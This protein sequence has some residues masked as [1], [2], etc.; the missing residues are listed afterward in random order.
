[1]YGQDRGKHAVLIYGQTALDMMLD[2]WREMFWPTSKALRAE[3]EAK[4]AVLKAKEDREKTTSWRIKTWPSRI[5][6][7]IRRH[8]VH[9][10]KHGRFAEKQVAP[11]VS[12]FAK[13]DGLSTQEI[14]NRQAR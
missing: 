9:V 4:A 12:P 1:M 13:L 14:L 5:G 2:R 3:L 8:V 6:Q 11:Y 10:V 7:R